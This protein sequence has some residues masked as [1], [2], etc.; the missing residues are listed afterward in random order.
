[1]WGTICFYKNFKKVSRKDIVS[2]K[3]QKSIEIFTKFLLHIYFSENL[4]SF[5]NYLPKTKHVLTYFIKDYYTWANSP[6]LLLFA[7]PIEP[8]LARTVELELLAEPLLGQKKL[9]QTI[10]VLLR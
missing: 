5:D 2:V 3:Q 9:L 10:S 7:L 8:R 6:P 4:E 1:M